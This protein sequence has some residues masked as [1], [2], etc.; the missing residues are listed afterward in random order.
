MS[1]TVNL[2]SRRT[3]EVKRFLEKFYKRKIEF[4]DGGKEWVCTY[5]KPLEAV[6]IISAVLDNDDTYQ[7]NICICLD[8]GQLHHVTHENHNEIVKDM[9][10]LFYNENV[11]SLN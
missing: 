6:D 8:G 2:W 7:I 11:L 4:D 10:Q 5:G 3:G 9:F 1:L